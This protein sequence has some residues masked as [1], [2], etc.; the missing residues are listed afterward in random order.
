MRFGRAARMHGL[1]ERAGDGCIEVSIELHVERLR[2]RE[3]DCAGE[4]YVGP[5]AAELELLDAR[6]PIRYENRGRS[7]LLQV[8]GADTEPKHGEGY[9]CA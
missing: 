4:P 1:R 2:S 8:V 7:F 9:L 6:R 5:R 3:T